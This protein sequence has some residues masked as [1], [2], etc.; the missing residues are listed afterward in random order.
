[1]NPLLFVNWYSVNSIFRVLMWL[2]AIG[3]AGVIVLHLISTTPP[4]HHTTQLMR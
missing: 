4:V 3:L 2:I 1:M